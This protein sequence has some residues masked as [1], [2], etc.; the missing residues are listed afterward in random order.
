MTA[1]AIA[2]NSTARPTSCP[3]ISRASSGS[4][5][6]ALAAACLAE[7]GLTPGKF[8]VPVLGLVL[9]GT[10]GNS[11]AGLLGEV[12]VPGSA[13]SEVGGSVTPGR[14]ALTVGVRTT[15]SVADPESDRDPLA[16]ALAVSLTCSPSGAVDCTSTAASSSSTW[17][18]GRLPT[19]HVVPSGTGQTMKL[20][21]ST[22][23]A[24][25][26]LARTLVPELAAVV[27]H[28]QTTYVALCPLCTSAPLDVD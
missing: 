8:G 17:P 12:P 24:D 23:R 25:P 5:A 11:P 4:V 27:L 28:T 21:A 1:M 18:V 2:P 3:P 13:G 10:V 19:L 7:C 15:T 26:T 6:D 16:D 22:W 14:L 20:G 9:G